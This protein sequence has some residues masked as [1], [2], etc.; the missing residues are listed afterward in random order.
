MKMLDNDVT[1]IKRVEPLD[2][3][4]LLHDATEE[5]ASRGY[6]PE[7]LSTE[8]QVREMLEAAQYVW[9]AFVSGSLVGMIAL[10]VR[11]AYS[12]PHALYVKP[13]YR[14]RNIGRALL[15]AAVRQAPNTPAV[16]VP[17]ALFDFYTNNGFSAVGYVMDKEE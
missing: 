15:S 4:E 8:A 12:V 13:E 14:N 17:A 16:A 5:W 1:L 3:F 10:T 2:V 7:F 11:D 9:G 6:S